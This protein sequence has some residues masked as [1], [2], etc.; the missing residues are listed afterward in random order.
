M[1]GKA[2]NI[3]H[4]SSS[5]ISNDGS[6]IKVGEDSAVKV[7]YGT[8]ISNGSINNSNSKSL[9]EFEGAIRINKSTDKLE[10]CNGSTWLEF[11]TTSDVGEDESMIYSLV[12]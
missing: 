2:I 10:Y 4:S 3:N 11:S 7:G 6:F 8:S 1:A 9:E 5:I 12:F